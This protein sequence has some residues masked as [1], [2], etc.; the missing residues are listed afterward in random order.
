MADFAVWA[1]LRDRVRVLVDG[2]A[3]AMDRDIA[4]WWRATVNG[5]G[6]GAVYGFLLDDEETPLPDPRSRWQP[7]GVQGTKPLS[8]PS[9]SFATFMG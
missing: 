3:Y 5:V 2:T 1:P 9:A 6:P 7:N 8:S 4:G